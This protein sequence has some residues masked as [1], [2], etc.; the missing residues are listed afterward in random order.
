M[1][2]VFRRHGGDFLTPGLGPLFTAILW[3]RFWWPPLSP[4]NV[5]FGCLTKKL[6]LSCRRIFTRQLQA[7][8]PKDGSCG[9]ELPVLW[10]GVSTVSANATTK[11]VL[12][13]WLS[14]ACDSRWPPF[15]SPRPILNSW[16]E[17][18]LLW[19]TK[20]LLCRMCQALGEPGV[21][22]LEIDGL[23]PE[24][25]SSTW[26]SSPVLISKKTLFLIWIWSS[27]SSTLLY[28]FWRFPPCSETILRYYNSS[29]VV[30]FSWTFLS[31]SS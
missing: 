27:Q 23:L 17:S 11:G 10:C 14:V 16:L 25:L 28:C 8:V 5:V 20:S 21:L 18:V 30:R 19:T 24:C 26:I 3:L 12:R 13:P 15:C 29:S 6:L 22:T 2:I 7:A 31:P 9:L 4:P 1:Y